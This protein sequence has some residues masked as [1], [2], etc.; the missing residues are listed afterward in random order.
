MYDLLTKIN[1]CKVMGD[2]ADISERVSRCL[3]L[4]LQ[5]SLCYIC[6]ID[7]GINVTY[8]VLQV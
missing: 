6:N 7:Y 1:Y 2:G 5:H 4:H 8:R 3:M